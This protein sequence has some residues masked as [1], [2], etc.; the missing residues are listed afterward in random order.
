MMDALNNQAIVIT[1]LSRRTH[2]GDARRAID[3]AI[4]APH[5]ERVHLLMDGRANKMRYEK[6]LAD[7]ERAEQQKS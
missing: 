4:P 7:A 3:L 2:L 5:R 6:Q 1:H